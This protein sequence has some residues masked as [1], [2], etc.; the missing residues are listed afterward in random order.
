MTNPRIL[1]VSNDEVLAQSVRVAA[2][3]GLRV[4]ACVSSA[5]LFRELHQEAGNVAAVV[6]RVIDLYGL[7]GELLVEQLRREWPAI[8]IVGLV[9]DFADLRGRPLK[10]SHLGAHAIVTRSQTHALGLSLI[11]KDAARA[12]AGKIVADELTMLLPPVVHSYVR[13][14]VRSPIPPTTVGR[15]AADGYRSPDSREALYTHGHGCW[16]ATVL[17]ATC[18]RSPVARANKPND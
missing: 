4:C 6:I 3:E 14:S 17:G 5:L 11:L 9:D 1:V 16:G 8:T 2:P 12:F 15:V 10:A 7:H 13:C 18:T